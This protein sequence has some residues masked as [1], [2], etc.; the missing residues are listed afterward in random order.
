MEIIKWL[1]DWYKLQCDGDWEHDHVINIETLDNP[2]WIVKI[3]LKD[4]ELENLELMVDDTERSEEDWFHYRIKDSEY[5]AAG[6][7]NKLLFLLEKFKE[8][9]EMHSKKNNQFDDGN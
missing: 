2:G 6:D 3:N 4:T 1:E 9:A 5:F 8:I 7:P